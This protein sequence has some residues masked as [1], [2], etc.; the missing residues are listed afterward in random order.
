MARR[1]GIGAVA[2]VALVG[3]GAPSAAQDY[4]TK[5]ITLMVPYAA[6]GPTDIVPRSLGQ[7]MGK[8]VRRSISFAIRRRK[9]RNTS[10]PAA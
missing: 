1:H 2:L 6:G 4:P 5:P 7:T 8:S 3:F 10:S 9:R